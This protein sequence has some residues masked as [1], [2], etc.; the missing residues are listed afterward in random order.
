MHC[1]LDAIKH[2]ENN[3]AK[4][5]EDFIKASMR[6]TAHYY[7]Y[8]ISIYQQNRAINRIRFLEQ[9][10]ATNRICFLDLT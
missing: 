8:C 10:I 6:L 2:N 9:N 4:L 1:I 5:N 3:F 7:Y